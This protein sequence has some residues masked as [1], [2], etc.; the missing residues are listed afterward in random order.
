MSVAVPSAMDKPQNQE[1]SNEGPGLSGPDYFS[2]VIEWEHSA[3]DIAAAP[4]DDIEDTVTDR[5]I[6]HWDVVEEASD[7][8]FPASDPPAWGSS[9][10]APSATTASAVECA[11][12]AIE[13]LS[14]VRRHA[15]GV[16][17][18]AVALFGALVHSI[19]RWRHHT[20]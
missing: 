13:P 12:Q 15:R 5:Q 1:S 8:S 7:E 10:A 4:E 19:R 16:A 11:P 20:A 18:F 3:D 17:L 6:R 2:V 9:H 14:W